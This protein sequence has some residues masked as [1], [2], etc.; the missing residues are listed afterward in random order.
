[1]LPVSYPDAEWFNVTPCCPERKR[2]GLGFLRADGTLARFA[3]SE[4]D[5]SMLMQALA[6][7]VKSPAGSQSATSELMPSDPR[8]VPSEGV[9]V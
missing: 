3:L 8:S 7:Y 1:M 6:F 5:A 4:S 9:K 2:L